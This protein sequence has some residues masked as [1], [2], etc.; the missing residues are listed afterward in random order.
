MLSLYPALSLRPCASHI[1]CIR[2]CWANP[3]RMTT[4]PCYAENTEERNSNLQGTQQ[5]Q[6]WG[7]R[8]LIFLLKLFPQP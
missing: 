2:F 8:L 1:L 5:N 7:P 3:T 6:N 4:P